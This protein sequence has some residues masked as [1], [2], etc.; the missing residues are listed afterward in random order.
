MSVNARLLEYIMYIT[1]FRIVF[2][3][4]GDLFILICVLF[5]ILFSILAR[6]WITI[7]YCGVIRKL[8]FN[9]FSSVFLNSC[10]GVCCSLTVL[11]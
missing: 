10:A 11:T 7:L 5:F 8:L 4:G 3:K 6:A 1:S 9:G 2:L